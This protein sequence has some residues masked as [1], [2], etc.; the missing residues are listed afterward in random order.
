[1]SRPGV[2][3]QRVLSC[4]W[5]GNSA[6]SAS[7]L[8]RFLSPRPAPAGRCY[9]CTRWIGSEQR[10]REAVNELDLLSC[11]LHQ[12]RTCLAEA[13]VAFGALLDSL[14]GVGRQVQPPAFAFLG[15]R[16]VGRHVQLALGCAMTAGVPADSGALSDA[17]AQ[18][19]PTLVEHGLELLVPLLFQRVDLLAKATLVLVRHGRKCITCSGPCQYNNRAQTPG[20]PPRLGNTSRGRACF[21]RVSS[22]GF[23]AHLVMRN[24]WRTPAVRRAATPGGRGATVA[25]AVRHRWRAAGRRWFAHR[26][27]AYLPRSSPAARRPLCHGGA[28]GGHPTL[29]NPY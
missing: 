13:T 17:P 18:Q 3:G 21:V 22:D 24:P 8:R 23:A 16:E 4:S 14:H 20:D 15:Y 12:T 5:S 11:E 26:S 7:S 19:R 28:G 2:E 1:M 9:R 27:L 10:V 6:N 29:I 25:N